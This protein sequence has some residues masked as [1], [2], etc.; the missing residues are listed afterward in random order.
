MK[1]VVKALQ[2]PRF[3]P[4]WI[5]VQLQDVNARLA[6][7][8]E[9]PNVSGAIVTGVAPGTPAA[10]APLVPGDIITSVGG[11]EQPDAR[12]LQRAI[13]K[14]EPGQPTTLSVWHWGRTKQLTVEG[15]PWSNFEELQSQVV[16]DQAQA[17]PSR[18]SVPFVQRRTFKDPAELDRAARRDRRRSAGTVANRGGVGD[19]CVGQRHG[20]DGR[21]RIKARPLPHER[22]R[23][24]LDG[25]GPLAGFGEPRLWR[26]MVRR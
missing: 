21:S 16:P 9:Q 1:S 2:D 17:D 23:P 20:R 14:V 12:P 4:N 10:Q 6:S 24:A 11:E 7:L 22:E 5:G 26:T 3:V 18:G 25:S 13:V 8:L 19:E 15:R